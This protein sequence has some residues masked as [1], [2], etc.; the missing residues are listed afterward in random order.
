[1]P[2]HR[3]PIAGPSITNLEIESIMDAAKNG[4]YDN[5]FEHII[6]FE[7]EFALYATRKYAISLP[8]CT[9]GLHL[10]L[11]ALDIGPGD[12]VIVPDCT[13]IASSA[14][15]SYVGAT[16]VFADINRQT[17]C[18]SPESFK[19]CI[20]ERT[21]AAIIVNLY[22]HM[23]EWDEISKIAKD[24][25]IHLIEDAAEAIGSTYRNSPAG[26]FGLCSAF[27]FHGSKTMT[28]GEGGMLVCDDES[29]Y[30]KVMKL[31]DHGRSPG[32]VMFKNDIVAF[33]YKMSPLQAA[34]GSAQLKR[35]P[36]LVSLKRRIFNWYKERLGGDH[37]MTL[38]PDHELV[39]NSYWMST[40][41]LDPA[42]GKSKEALIPLL[43]ESGV[44]VRPFFN[45]L[46][47]I[48]A[49]YHTDQAALARPRNMIAREISATGI[50]L[51]S[52][53]SLTEADIDQV[54]EVL[55]S[56]IDR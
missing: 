39:Y 6:R 4:W 19:E 23:A 10:A 9:A 42:C 2:S 40:A 7:S 25:N 24:N 21:R 28:T 49:Y 20:T 47:H 48:P 27:S 11:S 37:R 3:I 26:S 34:L 46:S 33:K 43:R 12:E 50:N 52:A 29:F 16:A 17:W 22:G 1:M 53:L 41:I 56:I 44:D 8:S 51:P 45:P 54:A 32:D 35:L 14:P 15:I 18:I 36:E 55:I 13:W 5:A 30:N 31:R 38:N